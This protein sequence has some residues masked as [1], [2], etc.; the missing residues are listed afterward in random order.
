M[1]VI[2]IPFSRRLCILKGIYPQDPRHRKKAS[3][4]SAYKTLYYRK[5]IQYLAHEPLLDK[6]REF[7][8]FVKKLKKALNKDDQLKADKLDENRPV[9]S[10]DHIVRER[11]VYIT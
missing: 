5:D 2:T 7:K 10:L 4:G 1:L 3:R 8:V 11:Y 6:T 9:Y